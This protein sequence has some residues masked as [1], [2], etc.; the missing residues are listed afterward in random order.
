MTDVQDKRPATA[1]SNGGGRLRMDPRIRERRVAVKRDEGRR[2]LRVVL[3]L[4]SVVVAIGVAYGITRSA[5]LDVDRVVVRGAAS[6]TSADISRAG[7][8]TGRPQLADLEPDEIALALERLP[9]VERASVE[10]HWP[11]TVDV[12]IIE[13]LPIATLAAEGGGWALVDRTGRVLAVQDADPQELAQVVA[14]AAPGPGR[15]VH[16]AAQAG[17][18]VVEALPAALSQLLETVTVAEDETIVLGL[19]S[20]PTVTFG[21]AEQVRPKLVALSTLLARVDLRGVKGIDVRVP[22]APVLRRT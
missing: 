11:S 8:L 6:T 13:R 19:K 4:G 22:A 7:G 20:T 15:Q 12:E 21:R 10:R 5:L 2:R 14:P 18:A 16:P 3:G 17:L 9:W 1:S